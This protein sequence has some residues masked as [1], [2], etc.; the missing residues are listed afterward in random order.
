M[1][2]TNGFKQNDGRWFG[3]EAMWKS[4]Y[5]ALV[6]YLRDSVPRWDETYRPS[7]VRPTDA[8][9]KLWNPLNSPAY[10]QIDLRREDCYGHLARPLIIMHGGSDPIVSTGEA[11]AYKNLVARTI[12][13]REAEKLLAVY[14]IPGMGHGGAQFDALVPAQI[15]ALEAMIDYQ[16]GRGPAPDLSSIGGYPREPVTGPGRS[17]GFYDLHHGDDDEHDD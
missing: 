9:V 12:G 17:L 14:Y 1:E 11:E 5:N 3:S 10:V 2:L 8:E 4:Q 6:G 15:D 7:N 16:Q 13:R